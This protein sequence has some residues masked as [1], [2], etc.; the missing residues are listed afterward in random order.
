LVSAMIGSFIPLTPFF[1]LLVP[2][3]IAASFIVSAATLFIAGVYKAK[4]TVGRP[5]RSGLELLIIG[6][7]AAL[8][9]YFIGTLFKP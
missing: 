5:F 8:I 2:Q 6:M 3:A 4:A 1:F 7:V 9:G